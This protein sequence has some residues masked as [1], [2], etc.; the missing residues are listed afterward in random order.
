[1]RPPSS[2]HR[3]GIVIVLVCVLLSQGAASF[4]ATVR[5]N[6]PVFTKHTIQSNMAE[7][8]SFLHVVD[9]DMDGDTDFLAGLSEMNKLSWWQNNGQGTFVEQTIAEGFGAAIS[10]HAK[11]IDNDGD[12]DI[13]VG[14]DA[15]TTTEVITWW[16][17]KGSNTFTKNILMEAGWRSRS[18]YAV[19]VNGDGD[20]DIIGSYGTSPSGEALWWENDGNSGFTQQHTIGSPLSSIDVTDLD[21]DRDSDLVGTDGVG[22][23]I[24]YEN[25]GSGNFTGQFIETGRTAWSVHAIDMD[26]DGDSDVLTTGHQSAYV[27]WWENDGDGGFTRHVIE[28]GFPGSSVYGADLD[29][30]GAVDV[31]GAAYDTDDLVWWQNDGSGTFTKHVIDAAFDGVCAASAADADGDGDLD[32]LAAAAN[33]DELAWWES[34]ASDSW[35]DFDLQFLHWLPNEPE[36]ME[37][38]RFDL[39]IGNSG[40][41]YAPVSGVIYLDFTLQDTGTGDK[42]F[43]RFPG[44]LD[45][46]PTND[47]QT[48]TIDL[49][50]FTRVGIDKVTACVS[51]EDEEANPSNNCKEKSITVHPNSSNPWRE[52]L[53][54]PIDALV[55]YV[56]ASTA[57]SLSAF[58]EAGTVFLARAPQCHLACNGAPAWDYDCVKAWI[59]LGIDAGVTALKELSPHKIIIALLKD[60]LMLLW[61][62]ADCADNLTQHYIRASI[63]EACHRNVPVNGLV[64]RSPIYIRAV[65]TSGRRAGFLGDGSIVTEIPDAEVF[66]SGEDKVVL[67]PGKDTAFVQLTGTAAGSFDLIV[68]LSRP[69][70]EVHTVTYE[71]V[72]VTPTTL[73]EIDVTS[74]QYTLA[75]DDDGDGTPDR[76]VEPAEEWITHIYR[77]YLP[78]VMRP[79]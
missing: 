7:I 10:V 4:P 39:R 5:A 25:D 21:G 37:D 50:W 16:E 26:N 9:L 22:R 73:G 30:D 61:S 62:N 48:L 42:W 60:G 18:V 31:L 46:M 79:Q 56:D 29:G 64:A 45:P 52:C 55:F 47:T 72:S 6:G 77:V 24:W 8:Y 68:S 74:G 63:E 13:V 71:D 28:S 57:G 3:V 58:Q 75:L 12:V 19:D 54:V 59:R 11:D 38:A 41:D 34:N 2:S 43:W 35:P 40:P 70:S 78:L 69:D 66:A 51:F 33:V 15:S 53:A 65:D 1:M 67:Y 44:S 23:T 36:V 14:A 27:T 20:V 49:F 32:V 17:N 76:Y